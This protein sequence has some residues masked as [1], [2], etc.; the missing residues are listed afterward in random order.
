M[1]TSQ[2]DYHYKNLMKF[3]AYKESDYLEVYVGD[4]SLK[5]WMK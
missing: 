2:L 1:E 3:G 5:A 4:R